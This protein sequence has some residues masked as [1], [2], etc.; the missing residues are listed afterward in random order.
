V[1]GGGSVQPRFICEGV[2]RPPSCR[3]RLQG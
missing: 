1:H 2:R 3:A